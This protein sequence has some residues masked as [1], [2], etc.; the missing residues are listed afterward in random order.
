MNHRRWKT[1]Q[2]WKFMEEKMETTHP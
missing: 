2:H 1:S